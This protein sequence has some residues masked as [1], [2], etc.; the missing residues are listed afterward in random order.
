[1]KKINLR[2]IL[3]GCGIVTILVMMTWASFKALSF[4][5]GKQLRSQMIVLFQR[6]IER[7]P[8]QDLSNIKIFFGQT[9]LVLGTIWIVNKDAEVLDQFNEQ[10]FPAHIRWPEVL[11]ETKRGSIKFLRS[12]GAVYAITPLDDLKSKFLIFSS[13][14]FSGPT[15]KI[16][17]ILTIVFSCLLV[18]ILM[19]A[20]CVIYFYVTKEQRVREL[21]AALSASEKKRIH[22]L[23]EICHDLR[24]PLA[25]IRSLSENLI[26]YS[27]RM[28]FVDQKRS[29]GLVIQESKYIEKLTEDLVTIS[30]VAGEPSLTQKI[31]VRELILEVV[32]VIQSQR[33]SPQKRILLELENSSYV[34][35]NID[36][37]RRMFRNG[38][39]NSFR[40]ANETIRIV[41]AHESKIVKVNIVDDGP[42][43]TEA[44]LASFGFR[45]SNRQL[46]KSNHMSLGLGSIIMNSIAQ[47]HY[48]AVR[49]ENVK[50]GKG[51]VIGANLCIQL[52]LA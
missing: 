25:S 6:I 12:N 13:R 34:L 15:N 26:D 50:N 22:A 14:G 4:D 18:I 10:K 32:E 28:S 27:D 35:G 2:K 31:D 41:I 38:I 48:G 24:T 46:K 43:L 3:A 9:E 19:L 5:S 47:K 11:R 21:I 16:F 42:G 51:E 37:L 30:L 23:Q 49:I 40:Y 17:S 1:M 29:L 39:E 44:D 45:K 52:P 33:W 36:L 8:A 20:L 7:T